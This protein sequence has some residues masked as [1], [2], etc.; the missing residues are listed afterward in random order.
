MLLSVKGTA[1]AWICLLLMVALAACQ[2][3]NVKNGDSPAIGSEVTEDRCGASTA[4]T[5][6]VELGNT[7]FD[8]S[9]SL[10]MAAGLN[11][12][13]GAERVANGKVDD[14]LK[15]MVEYQIRARLQ[16][17]DIAKFDWW[18]GE[19]TGFESP[20]LLLVTTEEWDNPH[21][22]DQT[23][24]KGSSFEGL[25]KLVRTGLKEGE[26]IS[27]SVFFDD[28][29]LGDVT[30]LASCVFLLATPREGLSIGWVTRAEVDLILVRSLE[31]DS[32]NVTRWGE[33]RVCV[34]PTYSIDEVYVFPK[35]VS[36]KLFDAH[37]EVSKELEARK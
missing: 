37:L 35:D 11:L 27:A 25:E 34:C 8:T 3:A 26:L 28:V 10:P 20:P 32:D 1:K 19:S 23:I 21:N 16:P 30:S 9:V 22:D 5:M 33:I 29:G 13:W 36:T 2:S 4:T 12:R 15:N 6:T 17:L 14:I 18:R 7:D 31:L 24:V